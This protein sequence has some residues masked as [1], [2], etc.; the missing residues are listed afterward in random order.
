MSNISS[1]DT[2]IYLGQELADYGFKD[3]HPFGPQRHDS[4]KAELLKQQLDRELI[5]HKPVLASVDRIGLFHTQDYIEKVADYSKTGVGYLDYG[6][7][8][9][10]ASL[11]VHSHLL[12]DFITP[13][14]IRP[15][16]S[17]FLM[18]AAS[19][20]STFEHNMALSGSHISIL[21]L[22][23][24]TAFS[25]VLKMTRIYFLQISTRM[26]VRFTRVRVLL[27]RPVLVLPKAR[28]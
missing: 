17:V 12:P 26:D 25:T 15:K 4:F 24:V 2:A 7:T 20:S 21:T 23:M 5:L 19:R 22:T 3:G 16:V 6:N 8:P 18:I 27:R 10:A 14:G 13:A 9:C 11:N 1:K 28:N